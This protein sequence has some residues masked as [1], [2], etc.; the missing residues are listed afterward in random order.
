LLRRLKALLLVVAMA[1]CAAPAARGESDAIADLG[2][3]LREEPFELT[4]DELEYD[5]LRALYI[6]RGNVRIEQEGRT[7]RAEWIA[8]NETTGTAIASGGVEFVDGGDVLRADFAEFNIHN[9]EGLIRDGAFES[10]ESQF[11]AYGEEIVKAEGQRYAFKKGEFTSCRCPKEDAREPWRIRASEIDVEVEGYGTARNTTVDVLGIPV[12][13]LPWM[14]YPIKTERQTGLLFPDVSLGSR[15]GVEVGLPFFWAVRDEVNLTLTPRWLSKRGFK[16]DAELEYVYGAESSGWLFGGYARDQKIEPDSFD[17]PYGR[18]RWSGLGAQDMFGPAGLRFQTEFL[19]ASDNEYALDFDELRGHR[20]DRFLE[21]KAFL[22]RGFRAGRYGLLAAA[23]YAD[24]MQNPDDQ[25]R[26]KYTLQR[27]PEVQAAVLP[28]PLAWL[29]WL[30]PS[31]D[32]DYTYFRPRDSAIE[33]R[34]TDRI[35][36]GFLDTGVDSLPTGQERGTP[37]DPHLDENIRIDPVNGTPTGTE[38]DGVFQEGEPLT[39]EGQRLWLHPRIALPFQLGGVEVYPEV[40]WH[41]TLYE[42]R[43]RDFEQRGFLTGRVDLRAPLRRRFGGG[44]VHVLE[45]LVG[46]AL[47]WADEDEQLDNPLFVPETALPQDRVRA[48][49]LDAVT[50]DT[51]DRIPRSNR[52]SFGFANRLYGPPSDGGPSRLLADFTLLGLYDFEDGEFGNALLDGRTYPFR[53]ARARFNLSFDP[54]ALRAD[55]ALAQIGWR[56]PAGHGLSI[57]YRY[58]RRI[59]DVFE[60]FLFGERYE[61]YSELEHVNQVDAGLQL[62]LLSRWTLAYRIAYSFDQDLMIANRGIVEYL[63][64]CRCW[65]LGAELRADRASGVEVRVVYRLM[66]LGRQIGSGDR[67]FLDAF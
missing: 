24:D 1:V 11:R 49:D 17:E 36:L 18:N 46:Y 35:E 58:V 22:G 53:Q 37:P 26:D 25:D 9:L 8:F 64:R 41:Q 3:S 67:G 13:W 48:L 62:V 52:V 60:D 2:D 27:L 54:E 38:G 23:T 32:V 10:D 47:A 40:G 43:Q 50:R 61:N 51:A 65:A 44:A 63:S 57:G 55:E 7:L 6:A 28:G 21:S 31:M 15:N 20:A 4:A 34:G 45:P 59:P 29:G 14:I 33:E 19:F 42:T 16:G 30:Q 56:H 39:D 5:H 66:G 12:V